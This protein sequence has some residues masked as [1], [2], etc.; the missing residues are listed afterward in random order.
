MGAENSVLEGCEWGPQIDCPPKFPWQMCPVTKADGTSGT[1]FDSKSSDKKNEELLQKFAST[2]RGL[3][4]PNIIRFIG[5]G[6]SSDGFW[7][8]TESVSPLFT[9]VSDISSQELCAGLHDVLQGLE[10]LHSK[11]GVCHNNV[12]LSSVFVSSDGSWKLGGLEF[13][14]KFHE[15]TQEYL[16]R[17][18]AFRQED[19]LSPEEKASSV[20]RDSSL[21]HARDVF[22]F[23]TLVEVILDLVREKDTCAQMLEQQLSVCLS[24]DPASRP[25]VSS[26]LSLPVFRSELIEII[27]FLRHITVKSDAE[28]KEFFRNLMSQLSR[29]P[30]MA[31]A[32][33]LV[34]PLLA[35]FVLLD[36]WAVV[37]V[38][39][40]LLTPK[41]A[42]R[43]LFAHSSPCVPGLLPEHLFRQYIINHIYN[44]FH[45]Y[46]SHIRLVLL[47]HFS[48]YVSMFTQQQLEDDIFLQV[49]LGVRDTDDRLVAASLRALAD[50]VPVLGGD[51]I[52]G[53]VRKPF[54]FHGMPK[55]MSALNLSKMNIPQ[56]ITAILADHKPLLKNLAAASNNSSVDD[57]CGATK[58]RIARD[59][60]R[61][62]E[63]AK[64]KREARKQLMKEKHVDKKQVNSSYG[65]KDGQTVSLTIEQAG[66]LDDDNV[67]S[68]SQPEDNES[69]DDDLQKFVREEND[70]DG[71]N[72]VPDWSDWEDA[73]QKISD[74]IESELETMSGTTTT[75]PKV[76]TSPSPYR[77]HTP[78]SPP[79]VRVDWSDIPEADRSIGKSTGG[80]RGGSLALKSNNLKKNAH[81]NG[82]DH[83]EEEN[84][85]SDTWENN[86][87][88][89]HPE[90]HLASSSDPMNNLTSAS[91]SKSRDGQ[92]LGVSAGKQQPTNASKLRL[93]D[94]LG[95]GFDI[96]SINIVKAS[97]PPELD[98]FA[99]MAPSIIEKKSSD[100][101]SLLESA[102]ADRAGDKIPVLSLP[103]LLPDTDSG[104]VTVNSK[105]FAAS[106][107]VDE[108]VAGWGE[109]DIDWGEEVAS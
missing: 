101:I 50:L 94:D 69:G 89:S 90:N 9:F 52:V 57:S 24:P 11:L 51:V 47:E 35:R 58:E 16:D 56:N 41:G 18:R 25:G 20:R 65:D 34:V 26:L 77:S 27:T 42:C 72:T 66:S 54:F 106:A 7:L 85:V 98:F 33:R 92:K 40:H 97:T 108:D 84:I 81:I 96:K 79:P 78:P 107:V 43:L 105:L 87:W 60:E 13:A 45:V 21:G 95:A 28:K 49:L 82:G 93:S 88:N 19:S 14:C 38:L 63:E 109:E 4:H 8:A 74:E 17:I 104:Q 30:E 83:L 1:V 68:T 15:A 76:Q 12:C 73:D 64:L 91:S 62:K 102:T 6:R 32:R 61:R 22:A 100:L 37:H 39:P 55:Q 80:T 2:L 71:D 36:E 53:G 48:Q 46:D 103:S 31:V 44:I 67:T 70:F 10:F 86:S 75:E 59:R 23:G 5:C 3:R 99:D 29:L